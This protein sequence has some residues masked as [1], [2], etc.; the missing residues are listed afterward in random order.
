[1]P[2]VTYPLPPALAQRARD[3]GS[4]ELTPVDPRDAATVVLLR[5]RTHGTGGTDGAGAAGGVHAYLMRRTGSMAFAAGMHAFPGGR[6]DPRDLAQP[7]PWHG[8]DPGE[9]AGRL[10]ADAA[11]TRALA[12]A[13]VRETFE[14]CGVLLAAPVGEASGTVVADTTGADW[15]ADR[16]AL[17]DRTLAFTDFLARR[18]LMLQ[19]ELLRPWAHWITPVFEERRYDTRFFVAALPAGQQARFVGGEADRVVWARPAD[20]AEGYARGELA[21]LPPTIATLRELAPYATIAQILAAA[22]QRT[23]VPITPRAVVD[24]DEVRLVVQG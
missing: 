3:F 12:A 23:I 2:G 18:G 16:R 9:W 7:V 14:E 24:G 21:M 1:M 19:A 4:G 11:L 10:G 20:A 8:P 5:E 15:E 22:D 6:V 13:A 17:V